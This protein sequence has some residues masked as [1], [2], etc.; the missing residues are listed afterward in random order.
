MVRLV[1]GE[2][3]LVY[4]P[5]S[6]ALNF[7]A[8][9]E[10]VIVEARFFRGIEARARDGQPRSYLTFFGA[11]PDHVGRDD[12]M[13]LEQM[14]ILMLL[15]FMILLVVV[16]LLVLAMARRQSHAKPLRSAHVVED[17]P[18][19]SEDPV[20]ALKKLKRTHDRSHP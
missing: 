17:G 10:L 18:L 19:I 6:R 12:V 11:Y 3:V 5:K 15:G 1:S 7:T 4:V 13:I 16:G 9:G 2:P 20:T 8:T 14:D